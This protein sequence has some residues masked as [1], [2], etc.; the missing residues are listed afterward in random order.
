MAPTSLRSVPGS[1]C[2]LSQRRSRPK[3]T[4]S[5]TDAPAAR[6]VRLSLGN[7]AREVTWERVETALIAQF[8]PVER[9]AVMPNR[10]TSLPQQA[11]VPSAAA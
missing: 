10:P 8:E 2:S 3:T 6:F 5:P 11:G 9:P 7:E 1:G 4:S